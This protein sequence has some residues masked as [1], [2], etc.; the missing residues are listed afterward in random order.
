MKTGIYFFD[1]VGKSVY[2]PLAFK[3][4]LLKVSLLKEQTGMDFLRFRKSKHFLMNCI[5]YS[6]FFCTDYVCR[7]VVKKLNLFVVNS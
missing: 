7:K 4:D 5:F 3:E 1:P 6:L 2:L